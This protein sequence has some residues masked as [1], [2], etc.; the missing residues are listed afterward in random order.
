M[1]NQYRKPKGAP[2]SA[3]GQYD[4]KPDMGLTGLP[5]LDPVSMTISELTATMRQDAVREP[6]VCKTEQETLNLLAQAATVRIEPSGFVLE[7]EH[8]DVVF[9]EINDGPML[10]KTVMRGDKRVRGAVCDVLRGRLEGVPAADRRRMVKA[11]WRAATPYER[12]HTIDAS[13]WRRYVP[14]TS[15]ANSLRRRKDADRAA[16]VLIDLHYEDAAAA[17]NVIRNGY[18]GP[19]DARAAWKFINYT[20]I[21]RYDKDVVDKAT[22][23]IMHHKGDAVREMG[24]V[25]KMVP[26]TRRYEL[27]EHGRRVKVPGMVNKPAAKGMA[28]RSYLRMMFQPTNGVPTREQT[29]Q[30]VRAFREL[31]DAPD[32]QAQAFWEMCYGNGSVPNPHGDLQFAKDLIRMHGKGA[33]V[34]LIDGASGARGGQGNMARMAAYHKVLSPEAARIFLGMEPGDARVAHT[35]RTRRVRNKVTG[36]M[37]DRLPARLTEMRSF[38]HAVYEI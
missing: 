22:G 26:G 7:D 4:N 37:E 32:L 13:P 19:D 33:G 10:D 24:L 29:R 27:D 15:I 16:Q 21:E 14:A 3:G 18:P 12:R 23:K 31:D 2:N 1:S 5:D 36:V 35:R 28:A 25:N 8:G 6:R 11:A 9:R 38:I 30:I 20:K 17:A 34:D